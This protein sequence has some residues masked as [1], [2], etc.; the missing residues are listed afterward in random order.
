MSLPL[1]QLKAQQTQTMVQMLWNQ[2]VV[3]THRC[4][5]RLTASLFQVVFL[6]C[7]W[8]RADL[9]LQNLLHLEI[10][11]WCV[12]ALR[13][14]QFINIPEWFYTHMWDLHRLEM[15]VK[16]FPLHPHTTT[17]QKNPPTNHTLSEGTAGMESVKKVFKCFPRLWPVE[18]PEGALVHSGGEWVVG[19]GF[20]GPGVGCC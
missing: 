8:I 13:F 5:V 3:S 11:N 12:Q 15:D 18:A 16:M 1:L 6:Q 7:F 19:A 14:V 4:S 20:N 17:T 9:N 10:F 2:E